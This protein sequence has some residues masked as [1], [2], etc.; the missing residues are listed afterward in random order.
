MNALKKYLLYA[1][2]NKEAFDKL[3]TA[4]LDENRKNLCIY[5]LIASVLFVLLIVANLAMR[6][7]AMVN[8]PVYI[9]MAALNL[10]LFAGAMK[11]PPK[12]PK[13]TMLLSYLFVCALYAFSLYITML[14]PDRPSVTTIVL[15]L[16]IP[17]LLIDRPAWLAALTA[18]VVAVLCVLSAHFKDAE[19]AS[20][21]I[22]NGISFGVIG[23]AAGIMQMR[24]RFRLLAQNREIRH[25]S[26]TDML[27]GAKNRNCYEKRLERYAAM[28]TENVIC[29]YAD[30]NG[31]HELNDTKG[32]RA[33]DAM[34]KA[35]VRE[36]SKAFGAENTYRVGGDEFVCFRV[37]APEE[38]TLSD[39]RKACD[40]LLRQGYHLS[41]GAA[42]A[43]KPRLNMSA[44]IGA[45]EASMYQ[46]K[47]RYYEQSGKDR[48]RYVQSN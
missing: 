11:L 10:G 35:V 24:T 16:A 42:C 27:T 40:A 9:A 23:I 12:T 37:D 38:Q 15:L 32:H 1:G 26:E 48:R 31:L 20:T 46:D 3:Q 41:V 43:Q 44:L 18:L 13:L 25:L 33:G 30:I 6:G 22:W 14:H 21:D 29:V 8:M 4:A 28:C 36:L 34:L 5:S 17:F 2:L 7:F 45:A 39:L 19:T 47:S